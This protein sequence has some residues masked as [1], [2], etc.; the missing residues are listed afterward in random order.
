MF[1]RIA[2]NSEQVQATSGPA[3]FQLLQKFGATRVW[4]LAHPGNGTEVTSVRFYQQKVAKMKTVRVDLLLFSV[5]LGL[6]MGD[7]RRF[8]CIR[9]RPVEAPG[10]PAASQQAALR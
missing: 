9:H 7:T 2:P 10:Q 6:Q 4:D 8:L 1:V 5:D 3:T